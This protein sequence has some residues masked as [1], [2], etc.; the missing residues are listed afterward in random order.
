MY[1]I[2][3]TNREELHGL[4]SGLAAFSEKN[5]AK[6]TTLAKETQSNP[7]F[8]HE[9]KI[10]VVEGK[11]AGDF[12]PTIEATLRNGQTHFEFYGAANSSDAIDLLSADPAIELV[13]VD[14]RLPGFEGFKLLAKLFQ[15]YPRLPVVVVTSHS[16]P[17][18][19]KLAALGNIGIITHPLNPI[20]LQG[21]VSSRLRMKNG[22]GSESLAQGLVAALLEKEGKTTLM[23]I[24]SGTQS[25]SCFI[26]DGQLVDAICGEKSGEEAMREL[27]A[28]RKCEI[29]F[30]DFADKR[31]KKK[32]KKTVLEILGSDHA[33]S[34][35]LKA[36]QSMSHAG[37]EESPGKGTN[38]EIES[39]Q[40]API[41]EEVEEKDAVKVS[42]DVGFLLDPKNSREDLV[43]AL[44]S[45]LERFKKING[46]KASAIM[47]FTGEI[48]AQDSIDPNIDLGM[49]GATFN[50]IFRTAHEASDKI[51]LEACREAAISTPKG[52]IIMRCS[53]VKSKVHYHIITIFSADGNQALAKMEMEKMIPPVMEELA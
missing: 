10:C 30:T 7:D 42:N 5:L 3:M 22:S 15:E 32:I 29:L 23:A 1:V 40:S 18:L 34:E 9:A 2:S 48:L 51:G 4:M 33:K 8:L 21:V 53:G 46:Y 47:N 36:V 13:I 24:S 27:L 45:Y 16:A 37:R 52:V 28:W 49:V 19:E 31:I 35:S 6:F 39:P 11:N 17:G 26:R 14:L 25:G 41:R 43:M 20:A 44:E 12:F 50:D 38:K